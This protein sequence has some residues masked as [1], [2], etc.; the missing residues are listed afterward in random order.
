MRFGRNTPRSSESRLTRPNTA[1]IANGFRHRSQS[2]TN[3]RSGSAPS[4]PRN[5][6]SAPFGLSPKS[7]SP[8]PEL[9]QPCALRPFTCSSQWVDNCAILSG[10]KRPMSSRQ[11][12]SPRI[13]NHRSGRMRARVL[14]VD[15]DEV[16]L[17]G[18]KELLE[19]AGYVVDL[20]SSFDDGK[21]R[22]RE[23]SPDL[24]RKS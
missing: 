23:H 3:I 2:C 14:I 4:V 6:P 1:R 20:A 24:D 21:Q 13:E 15:D 9:A 10:G 5:S 18:M 11:A 8:Q 7:S 12:D 19:D 22:L 16:Y 17:E